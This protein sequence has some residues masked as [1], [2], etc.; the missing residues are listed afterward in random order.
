MSTRPADV[1]WPSAWEPPG[2]STPAHQDVAGELARV[3]DG[4]PDVVFEAVGVP[5]LIQEAI[6]HV[7]FRGRLVVAGMCVQPDQIQPAAAMMK[8]ASVFFALAYEKDDFQYSVDMMDQERVDPA[9]MITERI[10]L[11]G[12]ADA[13]EALGN[14][15]EQCKILVDPRV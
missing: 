9:P 12:V 2:S 3:T 1:R 6:G 13:F 7:R 15:D 14:P 5:G 8:E 10:G 4:G 11:D